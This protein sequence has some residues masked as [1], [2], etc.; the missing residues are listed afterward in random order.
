MKKT[1]A[2]VIL[3][4][5]VLSTFA[6]LATPHVKA[7]QTTEAVIK[8]YSWYTAPADTFLALEEGGYAGDLIAVG[9]VQNTGTTTLGDIIV[10][11]EAYNSS[12]GMVCSSETPVLA[13]PLLPGQIAPFY[14]DFDAADLTTDSQAW[15]STV[16]NVTLSIIIADATNQTVYTDLTATSV[17]G[18]DNNGVYTIT[19]NVQNNGTQ[20]PSN[21]FVWATYYNAAGTV[22]GLNYTDYLTPNPAPG[23]IA[24]F[25]ATPADN[26]ASP[27]HSG[28]VTETDLSNSVK[29]YSLLIESTPPSSTSS[30]SNPTPTPSPTQS[31]SSPTPTPTSSSTQKSAKSLETYGAIAAVVIIAVVLVVFALSRTRRRKGPSETP[32]TFLPPPPP[33]PPPPT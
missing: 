32:E 28:T 33:P 21:V 25:T 9:E 31:A 12:N 26:S 23:D 3:F 4:I 19:G 17:T 14:M 1:A 2:I 10:G 5:L 18:F 24:P 20:T 16:T 22:I 15:V 29:S 7:Q 6:A 13:T 11:G 30:G 8:S 27:I